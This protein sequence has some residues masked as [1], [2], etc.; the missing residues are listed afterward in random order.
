MIQDQ[1]VQSVSKSIFYRFSGF[2]CVL[3]ISNTT[4][5]TESWFIYSC[6]SE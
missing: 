2:L 5:I 1:K 6:K 4:N 3:L